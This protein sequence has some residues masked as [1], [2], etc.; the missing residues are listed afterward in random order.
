VVYTAFAGYFLRAK[1]G[2]SVPQAAQLV[3]LGLLIFGLLQFAAGFVADL[4]IRLYGRKAMLVRVAGTYTL[5]W[6]L[7]ATLPLPLLAA[8]GA[9]LGG[10]AG[11][12]LPIVLSYLSEHT[13]RDRSGL[14]SS[15]QDVVMVA[16][17]V[18]A[19]V[20]GWL[21]V[22][23]GQTQA[24]V[25]AVSGMW[26]ATTVLLAWRLPA[27]ALLDEA[28]ID[29]RGVLRRRLRESMAALWQ[30]LADPATRRLKAVIAVA[31]TGPVIASTYLP[32]LLVGAVADPRRSA[33]YLAAATATGYV[34][35]MLLTPAL[36]HWA[37]RRGNKPALLLAVLGT[38]AVALA[39]V[40][41]S[42]QPPVIAGVIVLVSIGGRWLNVLQRAIQL[43]LATAEQRTTFF[44]A[45]QLP[46]FAGLPVGLLLAMVVIQL[47]GS[48]VNALLVV[49]LFFAAGAI[50]W[51]DQLWRDQ[52]GRR[53]HAALAGTR[54]PLAQ[55]GPFLPQP[56]VQE[57]MEVLLRVDAAES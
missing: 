50:L 30:L 32:L 45:N 46:F 25:L 51:G 42:S 14:V 33:G 15:F 20:G 7:F 39:L 28:A 27:E 40:G 31:A 29:T 43:E 35:A 19:L 44:M 55:V 9:G 8:I 23:R 17:Q 54:A 1:F 11:A 10:L 48:V 56:I 4:G 5:S 21:L 41:V 47:T 22:G 49:S 3:G 6:L 2:L 57:Q 13:R 16:G 18:I 36:G 37:D 26:A 34:L 52:L 24:L 53:R 12:G 38:V